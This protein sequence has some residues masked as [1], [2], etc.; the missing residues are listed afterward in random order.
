MLTSPASKTNSATSTY[1]LPAYGPHLISHVDI[2]T[3]SRPSVCAPG[4][5]RSHGLEQLYIYILL[6]LRPL[7][8]RCMPPDLAA[9]FPPPPRL[10]DGPDLVHHHTFFFISCPL[11][12]SC[13]EH[14]DGAWRACPYKYTTCHGHGDGARSN[15]PP[16]NTCYPNGRVSRPSATA[17]GR[18]EAFVRLTGWL[19][20][21]SALGA[22]HALPGLIFCSRGRT[23]QC[24]GARLATSARRAGGQM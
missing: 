3:R 8:F 19:R 15:R 21:S 12:C 24:G 6:A 22:M 13:I 5:C 10:Q 7:I 4:P 1:C 9:G 2:R 20:R 11:Y 14:G 16:G 17:G 23:I 18:R